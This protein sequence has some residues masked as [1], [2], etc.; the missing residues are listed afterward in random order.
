MGTG[1]EIDWL[2]KRNNKI[3][4]LLLKHAKGDHLSALPEELVE[5]YLLELRQLRARCIE[6]DKAWDADVNELERVLGER[7]QLQC[8]LQLIQQEAD[9]IPE[10]G[11]IRAILQRLKK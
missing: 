6:I 11:S 7:N 8:L 5:L 3:I 4:R 9:K 10:A 2:R 1:T